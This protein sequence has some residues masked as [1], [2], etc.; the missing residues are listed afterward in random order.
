[1]HVAKGSAS[2]L[3]SHGRGLGPQDALKKN[4]EAFFGLWKETLG[5]LD[6]CR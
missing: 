3:S 2:L 1:M 6:L 5:S 4:I